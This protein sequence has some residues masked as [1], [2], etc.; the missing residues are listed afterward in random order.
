MIRDARTWEL[1]GGSHAENWP[2]SSI[3]QDISES[4]VIS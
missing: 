4:Q 2:Y 1:F 3:E